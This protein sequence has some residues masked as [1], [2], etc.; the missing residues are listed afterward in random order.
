MQGEMTLTEA[1]KI[2]GLSPDEDPRPQLAGFRAMRERHAEIVSTAPNDELA[3]RYQE[4]LVELD[5]ALAAVREYLEALG[6]VPRLADVKVEEAP[7]AERG[8]PVSGE[9]FLAFETG[10]GEDDAVLGLET[11]MLG[12]DD[13][14]PVSELANLP[15]KKLLKGFEASYLTFGNAIEAGNDSLEKHADAFEDGSDPAIQLISIKE[16]RELV[17]APIAFGGK[18]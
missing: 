9:G 12:N 11:T 18:D 17:I 1:R 14:E 7:P 4:A 2:L 16:A 8:H 5:R 6:L 3:Q 13:L 10:E 15:E